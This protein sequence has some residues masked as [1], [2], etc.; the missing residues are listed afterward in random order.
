MKLDTHNCISEIKITDNYKIVINQKTTQN[1]S[2]FNTDYF[3][4]LHKNKYLSV[5]NFSLVKNKSLES[6]GIFHI[7]EKENGDFVNPCNGSYG[8]FEFSKRVPFE[9]KEKFILQILDLIKKSKEISITMSPNIYAQENNSEILNILIR[10]KFRIEKIEVNQFIDL[11]NYSY[12]RDMSYGNKKRVKKCENNKIKFQKLEEKEYNLAYKIIAANRKRRG[13]PLTMKWESMIEMVET[14]KDKMHFFGL[15]NERSYIASAICINVLSDVLYVFYW[16][17]IDGLENL[18]P[19]A[20]LSKNLVEYA[21]K[22]NYRILDIGISSENSIPNI[23]LLNFKK[24]IGCISCNK[25][26]LKKNFKDL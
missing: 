14:F 2:I 21:S 13:F 3:L 4:G 23:G 25:F 6:V 12:D 10:N 16:G 22:E 9:I 18:S 5:Y 8:N 11:K 24:N 17:E 19:I 20:Y 26:Y 15:K 1:F 7:A